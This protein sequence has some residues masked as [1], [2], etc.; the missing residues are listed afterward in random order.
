MI[1]SEYG[2]GWSEGCTPAMGV[3]ERQN[4]RTV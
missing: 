1:F 3:L 2:T 4:G